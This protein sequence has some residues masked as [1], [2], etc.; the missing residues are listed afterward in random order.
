MP[1]NNDVFALHVNEFIF[2]TTLEELGSTDII[3]HSPTEFHL[4]HNHRSVDGKVHECDL[5]GKKLRV[6]V[7]GE[8]FDVEIKDPLDQMLEKM[9]FGMADGKHIED[10]R[11]P[12]PGL[13][14]HVSV[15]EG[16]EI[17]E[18]EP[19]LVLEAMKM[20]NSIILH[21]DAKIKKILVKT[22]QSVEKGQVLVEL[23]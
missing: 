17:K 16:Q 7:E 13:V 20:E 8:M 22:G 10:I 1:G 15:T 21:G 6:E 11:A 12:M 3:T 23:E 4:I 19:V 18:G 14:L 2:L 9:G 5:S